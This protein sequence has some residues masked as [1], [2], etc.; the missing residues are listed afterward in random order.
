VSKTEKSKK[1]GVSR[2]MVFNTDAG[3]LRTDPDSVGRSEK[4]ALNHRNVLTFV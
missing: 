3:I 4:F 1:K 2:F